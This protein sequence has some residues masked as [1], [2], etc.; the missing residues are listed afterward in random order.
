MTGL[1]VG[2]PSMFLNLTEVTDLTSIGT[3]F[4]FLLVSGGV[5]FLDREKA[6]KGRFHL[7]YFSGRYVV[8]AILVATVTSLAVFAPSAISDFFSM[9]APLASKIP[10]A[11]FAVFFVV[12]AVLSFVKRLSLIPVMGLLTCGYL[13]TELGTTNWIRFGAWLIIGLSIYFLYSRK[14]SKLRG[15]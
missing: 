3:L 4:A 10:M 13:M 6:V 9:R 1:M 8:P 11:V 15:A 14:R 12:I 5:L 7:P 2:I